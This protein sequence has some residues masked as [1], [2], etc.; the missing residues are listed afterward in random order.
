MAAGDR[1]P[2]RQSRFGEQRNPRQGRSCLAY[3]RVRRWPWVFGPVRVSR[4]RCGGVPC[5]TGRGGAHGGQLEHDA[6]CGGGNSARRRASSEAEPLPVMI[7]TPLFS[8]PRGPSRRGDCGAPVS[9]AAIRCC[10]TPKLVTQCSDTVGP[11]QWRRCGATGSAAKS[12][13]RTR[14]N[15]RRP[16]QT[17]TAARSG[18]CACAGSPAS[19]CTSPGWATSC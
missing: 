6:A 5:S 19:P 13:R 14:P 9:R 18:R 15:C 4:T 7:G 12:L 17:H 8:I 16:S 11:E 10:L 3:C 1:G 2:H